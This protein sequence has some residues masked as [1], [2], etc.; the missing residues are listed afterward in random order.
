[1]RQIG[2]V[3]QVT[4]PTCGAGELQ[5]WRGPYLYKCNVCSHAIDAALF[6]TLKQI[7]A[8]P[9]AFGKHACECGY[10]EMRRLPNGVFHCPACGSEVLLTIQGYLREL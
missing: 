1:M 9:D 5:P 3:N 8:L 10:P 4:C 6:R 7:A 2:S